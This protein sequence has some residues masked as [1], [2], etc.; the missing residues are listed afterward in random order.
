M[1]LS[2]QGSQNAKSILDSAT[3][4]GKTGV[5]GLVFVAVDKAGQT[6]VEHASGTK[7]INSAE[8]VDFDTTFWFASMTKLVTVIAILQLVEREI[9]GLDDPEIVKKYA[10]EIGKKRVYVDGVNGADQQTDITLRMLLAHTAGFAYSFLDPRVSMQSR[11]MGITELH[12]DV[13]DIFES[14][15]VNQPG[16]MWEYG[17][18]PLCL[19]S[20]HPQFISSHGFLDQH[21]LGWHYPRTGHWRE[22]E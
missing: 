1:P 19:V 17:V 18:R 15:M 6:L 10:P 8:P 5:P 13:Q 16:S 7:S 3:S 14:P 11:P 9:L 12:G 20:S 2:S 4:D 22:T 21:R